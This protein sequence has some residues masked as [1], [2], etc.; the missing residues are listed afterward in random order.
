MVK[1]AEYYV[2]V[3]IDN[4]PRIQRNDD[5]AKLGVNIVGL[6]VDF[7]GEIPPASNFKKDTI[8]WRAD[9]MRTVSA[10]YQQSIALMM[11]LTKKQFRAVI[12]HYYLLNRWPEDS[13]VRLRTK[14]Q[15]AQYLGIDCHP[16][17]IL[18]NRAIHVLNEIIGQNKF[19]ECEI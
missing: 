12:Q 18:V 17:A 5:I 16:W 6:L 3:F 7:K 2:A 8:G 4:H 14:E 11:M 9:K 13:Q 19:A 15:I 10:D 1:D